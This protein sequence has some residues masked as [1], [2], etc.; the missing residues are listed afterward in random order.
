M[1]GSLLIRHD[2]LIIEH[3]LNEKIDELTAFIDGR[4]YLASSDVQDAWDRRSEY[5]GILVRLGPVVSY[6]EK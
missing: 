5:H 3:L 6:P 4:P 2:A 1:S